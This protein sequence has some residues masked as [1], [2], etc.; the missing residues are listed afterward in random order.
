MKWEYA[1]LSFTTRASQ[2]NGEWIWTNTA[3]LSMRAAY[4]ARWTNTALASA[5][6]G[7]GEVSVWVPSPDNQSPYRVEARGPI[8]LLGDL[9]W[10]IVAAKDLASLARQDADPG[11]MVMTS[12]PYKY[13]YTLKRQAP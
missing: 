4:V 2:R 6:W 13:Q 11:W 7:I 12:F 10:E 8:D 1:F 9:G 5:T 3:E